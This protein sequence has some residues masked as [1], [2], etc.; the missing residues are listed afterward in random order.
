MLG[1]PYDPSPATNGGAGSPQ[2]NSPVGGAGSTTNRIYGS[3]VN[4]RFIPPMPFFPTALLVSQ[5]QALPV[6][7]P[8]KGGNDIAAEDHRGKIL[9]NDDDIYP[10]M[11]PASDSTNSAGAAVGVSGDEAGLSAF[12]RMVGKRLDLVFY[13]LDGLTLLLLLLLLY[14]V[15]RYLRSLRQNPESPAGFE[16]GSGD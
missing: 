16:G 6:S 9:A 3:P 14:F 4:P 13:W 2:T 12:D 11:A 5:I 7:T 10:T 15:W 1:S 8:V